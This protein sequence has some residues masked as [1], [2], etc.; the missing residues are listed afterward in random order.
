ME[1]AASIFLAPLEG[2]AVESEHAGVSVYEDTCNKMMLNDTETYCE[3]FIAFGLLAQF[4]VTPK[5]GCHF[6]ACSKG[7]LNGPLPTLATCS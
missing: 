7:S 6:V 2:Y 1:S 5:I 4:G 3:V